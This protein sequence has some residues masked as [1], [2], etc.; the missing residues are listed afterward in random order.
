MLYEPVIQ[1][2]V[3]TLDYQVDVLRLD[4]MDEEISGN[5]WFKLK[6]NIEAAQKSGYGHIITFGGAFSNHLAATAAACKKAK[7][8][9]TAVIRGEEQIPLNTTLA[10]AQN[11]GMQLHFVSREDYDK[12]TESEFHHYLENLFGS[13]Y[14]IPEG[15]NNEK[16]VMGC[17]EIL[18]PN[19]N[20]DYIC[21]ACGTGATYTGLV[22]SV[23]Q[24]Q[25]VIGISV[26][27]GENL[28]V[29]DVK[30]TLKKMF[31]EKS[32]LI[33][34]NEALQTEVIQDNCITNLYAFKGYAKLDQELIEFKIK[35][36]SEY[37]IQLDYVYTN[38]LVYAVF[39]LLTKKKFRSGSSILIIHSGGL[40]G[41]EGFEARY[42]LMPSR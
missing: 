3:H 23:H 33:L 1:S 41:N 32:F 42:H 31:P 4:L 34:G 10:R 21:C 28:L 16:G 26:L 7:V 8:K 30:A 24:H 18:D 38:K 15:G 40:Q 5:K 17:Q 27:K 2:L 6:Y 13:H 22:A 39:D 37:K 36:E 25:K 29:E 14:L 20:Y 35:F 19:W 12:K 9:C 11:N